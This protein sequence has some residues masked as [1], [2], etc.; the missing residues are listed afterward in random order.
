MKKILLISIMQNV[1]E[2]LKKVEPELTGKTVTYIPTAALGEDDG[3]EEEIRRM[4]AEEARML[5][6]LGLTVDTLEVSAAS[7]ERISDSLKKSDMIFVGGGNT[8]FL[9]QEL[10]RTGADQ[11]LIREVNLGKMYIGESAGAIVACPDIGYSKVM[12]VPEKAPDLSDYSALSLVDFYVVP[13]LGNREMGAAAAEIVRKYGQEI[14]LKVLTDDQ[15]V[16][17]QGESTEIL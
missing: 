4:V 12:D 2:I 15:A 7:L 9:L 14:E 8:F 6:N 5:G 3:G 1:T 17:V 11:M 16:F 13:H 10:K